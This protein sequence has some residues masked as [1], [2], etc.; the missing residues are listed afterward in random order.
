MAANCV[1]DISHNNVPP[2]IGHLDLTKA[3]ADGVTAVFI[4]ASQGAQWNDPLFHEHVPKAVEASLLIGAYHF[5]TG[6]DAAAQVAHFQQVIASAGVP[7]VPALDLEY[8]P[9]PGATQMTVELAEQFIQAWI[10]QT[11]KPPVLY[12]GGDLRTALKGVANPTLAQCPLWLADY[13]SEP[14]LLTGWDAWTFWQYTADNHIPG[15]GG[16]GKVD[17][18]YFNGEATDCAAWWAENLW[19]PTVLP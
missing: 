5:G 1:I 9:A 8:N 11:G 19:T 18:S 4:K 6:V 3:V 12:A 10:D 14:H 15:I 13:R 2:G 17:R 16:I 7:V